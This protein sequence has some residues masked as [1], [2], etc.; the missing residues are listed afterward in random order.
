ML[1]I[2]AALVALFIV[3]A[4]ALSLASRQGSP[5]GLLVGRLHPCPDTPN[6]VCSE[7][8]K[9]AAAFVDPLVIDSESGAA[10][11]WA[12]K[13]V[14]DMGGELSRVED[15]YLAATFRT[16][17][18]RFVDDVELRLDRAKGLIH[19]R[20]A[21]RVGRSDVGTNRKRVAELRRRYHQ[22][23]ASAKQ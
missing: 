22:P 14:T 15:D 16:P 11:E 12:Q 9:Q 21:S 3:T 19:I 7:Y 23:V 18:F 6:C 2:V 20:S 1:Y 17:L 10:W 13:A 5:A 8:P 4:A